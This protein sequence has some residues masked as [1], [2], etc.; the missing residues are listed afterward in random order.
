MFELGIVTDEIDLD[1]KKSI[2][3][4]LDFG[5]S[6]YE[7]RCLGS[8]EKRIPY[9]D[10]ED[11]DFLL[12][13][14][15]EGTIEITAL[16]PGTFKIKPSESDK[17]QKE[18]EETLPKT[19]ELAKKFNAD[20]IITFG[21]M[22]DGTEESDVVELLR[23]AG[24]MAAEHNLKLAVENEPGA[25]LDTGE[26]TARLINKVAMDNVKVNWDPGNALSSGDIPYPIG[27]EHVKDLI[28]NFHIKD[29]IPVP[30]DKWENKLL[31]DGGVNWLGQLNALY[32]DQRLPYLTL[33]THVF[34]LLES[35]EED[36]KRLDV[37]FD[38]VKKLNP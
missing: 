32:K 16:S 2:K 24:K 31:N 36:L 27:Y 14:L 28:I 21:F 17:L 3:H 26:N 33:E 18:M 23:R 4:G 10:Q 8:Y 22:R 34:P 6:K 20:K 15:A 38:A 29:S 35:T 11:I 5:L 25:Y 12:N 30:P 13:L 19:F 37:L 7:I 9:V 1:V